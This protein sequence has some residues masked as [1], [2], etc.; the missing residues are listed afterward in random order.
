MN[1]TT[2]LLIEEQKRSD[3]WRSL[4]LSLAAILG[5]IVLYYFFPQLF[6]VA[7]NELNN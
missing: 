3:E 2:R 4:A 6:N 7:P 1:E 5:L